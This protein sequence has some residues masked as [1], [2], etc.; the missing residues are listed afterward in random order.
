MKEEK[1]LSIFH[2]QKFFKAVVDIMKLKF[3]LFF[4]ILV[5]L[6]YFLLSLDT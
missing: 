6:R 2:F 4:T 1:I 5:I 3:V